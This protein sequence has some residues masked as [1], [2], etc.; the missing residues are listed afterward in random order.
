MDNGV[1]QCAIYS[2]L[3]PSSIVIHLCHHGPW[4]NCDFPFLYLYITYIDSSEPHDVFGIAEF[5]RTRLSKEVLQSLFEQ[6]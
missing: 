5:C 2:D 4:V 1:L 6:A 3:F